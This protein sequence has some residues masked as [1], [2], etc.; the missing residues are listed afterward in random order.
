[1][2]GEQHQQKQ[3]LIFMHD[4]TYIWSMRFIK[5]EEGVNMVVGLE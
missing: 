3:K 4:N 5:R 1:M 2:F